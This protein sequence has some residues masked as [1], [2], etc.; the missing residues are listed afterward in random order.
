MTSPARAPSAAAAAA[1]ER[2]RHH[3]PRFRWILLGLVVALGALWLAPTIAAFV[4]DL[5]FEGLR[6]PY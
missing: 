5:D 4:G 6:H 3:L 2:R 1:A